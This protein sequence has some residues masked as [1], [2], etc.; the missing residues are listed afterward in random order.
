LKVYPGTDERGRYISGIALLGRKL[1]EPVK[2]P[3]V[4]HF[5]ANRVS[6]FKILLKMLPKLIGVH[7]SP[8]GQG[9]ATPSSDGWSSFT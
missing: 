9:I 3:A 5:E 7:C 1:N 4:P 2:E 8:P 6:E